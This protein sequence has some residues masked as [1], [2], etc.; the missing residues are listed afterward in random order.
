VNWEGG[1][2][3]CEQCGEPIESA[4]GSPEEIADERTAEDWKRHAE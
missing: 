4:Y 2:L 3:E 1:E